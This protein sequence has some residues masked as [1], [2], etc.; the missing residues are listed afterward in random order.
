MAIGQPRRRILEL[1]ALRGVAAIM[2][3]FFHYSARFD[4]Y[5]GHSPALGWEISWGHLGVHLFFIISGFVIFLTLQR[6]RNPRDFVVSR[7]ARLYPAYWVS[8]L[9]TFTVLSI[10]GLP[11]KEISTSQLAVNMTMLQNFLGVPA[12]DGVYW[13]LR[14]ELTFYF[15]IFLLFVLGKM[16]RIITVAWIWLAGMT[17]TAFIPLGKWAFVEAL[18]LWNF[19]YLFIAGIGFFFVFSGKRD[20]KIHALI[21]ACLIPAYLRLEL[22]EAMA[23]TLFFGIFFLFA[24]GK[25][26]WFSHKILIVGGSISY[27]LY[28]IHQ[29][30]GYVIL[31]QL[32]GW[33]VSSSIKVALAMAIVIAVS[34]VIHRTVE[35]PSRKKIRTWYKNR[36]DSNS[37]KAA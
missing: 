31:Q 26:Q 16:D 22:Y 35:E 33:N 28:L 20:W 15:W 27:V 4:A 7:F 8:V 30:V 21:L 14:V 18:L 17:L 32:K 34:W 23:V 9:F 36:F 13:S 1:D 25:L 10:W 6:T 19:G 2:V 5:Y 11:G 24:Y 29:N 12:V 37:S 3:V